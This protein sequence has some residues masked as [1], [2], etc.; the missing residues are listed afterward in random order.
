MTSDVE[1]QR[2]IEEREVPTGEATQTRSRGPVAWR[3][4]FAGVAWPA[5]WW[6]SSSAPS[7]WCSSVS[8]S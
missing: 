8:A 5:G 1:V 7:C 4:A 2:G 6:G 3:A